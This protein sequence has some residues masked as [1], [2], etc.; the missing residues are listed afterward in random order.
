MVSPAMFTG[1]LRLGKCAFGYNPALLFQSYL[2]RSSPIKLNVAYFLI[3]VHKVCNGFE[4]TKLPRGRQQTKVT[5]NFA[6][7]SIEHSIRYVCNN[8]MKPPILGKGEKNPPLLYI[9]AW[10]LLLASLNLQVEFCGC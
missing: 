1:S 5:H 8:F 9:P 4:R 2:L 3:S 10:R 7:S 6:S